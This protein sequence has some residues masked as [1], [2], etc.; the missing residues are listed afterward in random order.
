MKENKM[1]AGLIAGLNIA[2]LVCLI[3][4]LV[5]YLTHN[6]QVTYPDAMLPAEW[7]DL[8]GMALTVGTIPLFMVNLLGFLFIRA[9]RT[10]FKFLFFLPSVV[11][12]AAVVHYWITSLA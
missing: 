3:C 10:G 4:L 5:P 11:C 6:T 7:C 9:R 1:M 2:G 8:A 12:I